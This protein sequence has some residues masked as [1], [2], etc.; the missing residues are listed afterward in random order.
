MMNYDLV[1]RPQI[2]PLC[3]LSR[4]CSTFSRHV[5]TEISLRIASDIT[6]RGEIGT[7]HSVVLC[8]SIALA[9][10]SQKSSYS[11]R[12]QC[13]WS[14]YEIPDWIRTLYSYSSIPG[15]KSPQQR[16]KTWSSTGLSPSLTE[17]DRD[18]WAIQWSFKAF[19]PT[20]HGYL[21]LGHYYKIK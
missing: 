20:C 12:T 21:S 10:M 19:C 7:Q 16:G 2:K 17:T 13:I 18:M 14:C 3:N 4:G 11:D 9:W 6:D 8:V 15:E 5:H 1:E